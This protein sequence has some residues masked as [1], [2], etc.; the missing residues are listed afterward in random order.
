M[1]DFGV[2]PAG[3]TKMRLPECILAMSQALQNAFG[4]IQ[5]G[6]NA[7]FGLVLGIIGDAQAVQWEH[8][9]GVYGSMYPPTAVGAALDLAVSFSGVKRLPEQK[10]RVTGALYGTE[11]TVVPD[12]TVVRVAGT[13]NAMQLVGNTTITA[14]EAYDVTLTPVAA[15]NATYR[16]TI[17]GSAYTYISGTGSTVTTIASQLA[18]KLLASGLTVITTTST[19][20]LL[21]PGGAS[22]T[23]TA[24]PNIAI[25]KIGS[26][27]YFEAQQAGAFDIPAGSLTDLVTRTSGLDRVSNDYP[28]SPGRLRETDAELRLRY[29]NG[30]FQL[31]AGTMPAIR[32]NLLANVPGVT[33]A[34]VLANETNSTDSAGRPPHCIECVVKGGLD[35]DV[36][37]EL[38]R[39][40]AAGIDTF[41]TSSQ[42]VL[43]SENISHT[44]RF[45]RPQQV[46]VWVKAVTTL[47]SEEEFPATGLTVIQ[48]AIVTT[49][50]SLDIGQDVV[51]QRFLGPIYSSTTGL[52]NVVIT[53]ASSTNP[54]TVPTSGTYTAA[55]ISI[56]PTQEA[57]FDLSRVSVT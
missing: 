13:Q 48:R 22:F 6:P 52:A 50:N 10:G 40:K 2:T 9:E 55:N 36:A 15:D 32:A 20:Q 26:V 3:F 37:K 7:V 38:F 12:R 14:S 21:G 8:M 46:Y 35:V 4:D 17:E 53:M 29:K 19:V 23:I 51:I 39:I 28:G 47:L 44:T 1:A 45:S 56:L 41:G 54:A 49:G 24:T 5:T 25:S 27:G 42:V 33:A 30:V 57:V 43:D 34:V 31:G 18:T 11:G 16:V